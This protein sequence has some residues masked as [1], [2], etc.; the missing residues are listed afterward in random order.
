MT[1]SASKF[2]LTHL[3]Q[4][5][6]YR[7]GQIRRWKA[8]GG[9]TT[10]FINTLWAGV[11]EQLYE[12]DDPA[13]IYG[14]LVVLKTTNGLAP[15][16]EMAMITDYDSASQTIT[17][18]A[19]TA[20]IDAGDLIGIASPLFPF[21]DM[22]E[23]ANI[24]LQKLGEIDLVDTS[25]TTVAN[26]TEYILPAP[27]TRRPLRVRRQLTN[28]SLNKAWE[29][30][31][32]WDT[33]PKLPD[34]DW[35]LT[36]PPTEQGYTLEILYRAF[37]P[38]LTAYSSTIAS[39]IDPELAIASLIT[40]AYQWYNNQTGGSNQ[41]FL[42]RENKSLTDLEAALAKYPLERTSEQISG[43][44]HWNRRGEYVPLTSDLRY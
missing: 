28:N 40:E 6:W 43:M 19:L 17:I 26:Q 41:Y 5:A 15:E 1:Y 20:T 24:A 32:G 9:N 25:L 27:I 42:Q 44:P 13:L 33:I 29:L 18:D 11:E 35:L 12:D 34:V 7:M 3:L 21:Q 37:H 16:G 2:Q 8:T 38:Q 30:V 31:S 23:L 39:I 22:T 10:S 36:V 14:T 4:D